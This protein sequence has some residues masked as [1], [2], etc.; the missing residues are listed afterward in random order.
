MDSVALKEFAR[1]KQLELEYD[2]MSEIDEVNKSDILPAT[3]SFDD[4]NLEKSLV[5]PAD[6]CH[7]KPCLD[8]EPDRKNCDFAARNSIHLGKRTGFILKNRRKID[9]QG[10]EYIRQVAEPCTCHP[11]FSQINDALLNNETYSIN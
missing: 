10:N 11:G 6:A 9:E 3:P 2:P 5:C 1:E 7:W 4:T 8:C